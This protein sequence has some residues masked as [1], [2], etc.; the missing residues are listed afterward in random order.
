MN[1]FLSTTISL[2]LLAT[3][4]V[5]KEVAYRGS[6]EA[7]RTG[8]PVDQARGTVFLDANRNSRHDPGE[9][10][11]AGVMVSNGREVVT[12]RADGGYELPAYDD[13]NLFITKPAGYVTP[14]NDEMVPQF[15]YIHK[16]AGSPDLR[17]GGIA[18]TGPLPQAV[19]FPLIKDSVRDRFSC[20]VFGDTQAYT[21]AELG[22][23]RETAGKL[24]AERDNTATECLI[25]TGDVMGDDLSLYPRFKRIT[26]LGGVPQYFVG[27]NHD[28]DLDAETDQHSFDTFR[29]EWGPEYYSFDIGQVHFVGLDNV[30]YPCNGVDPHPF[31]AT[32]RS[33]TYNGVISQRQLEWLEND[34]A[35]VPKNKLI[36]LF[37][38][39]PFASFSDSTLSKH[40]TDNLHA[41]YRIVQGRPTLGLAG[42]THTT[43]QILP[44]ESYFGWQKNTGTGSAQF[45]QII[46]GAVSGSWWSGDLDDQGVPR[47]TQRLGSPRGYYRIDFN[48][49]SYTDTFIRFH[50]KEDAQFHAGFNT[51]RFRSWARK[52]LDYTTA[53]SGS[54]DQIPAVT[55]HDL[56]DPHLLTLEDLEAGTW[57]AVNVWNGSRDSTV[58][59]LV[60]GEKIVAHRTQA[61][62]G[63]ARHSGVDYADPVALALQSTVGRVA[64]RSTQGGEQT[65]GFSTW[66]GVAWK[67]LRPGPLKRNFLT[68][69][70]SHLWRADLPSTLT[71]GAHTLTVSTTDRYG[72]TYRDLIS[73]EVVETLPNPGWQKQGWNP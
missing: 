3:G 18:P 69:H 37:T 25:F 52:L 48:G 30:R 68:D 36:V 45:H 39:I 1:R 6:V 10:G 62:N 17:F 24:L 38:H 73:F 64:Y 32:D 15:S 43:E 14:V 12:T 40:Q 46:T 71:P 51:P 35:H 49:S 59:A 22:Y 5:A 70:S 34:L 54:W 23:V 56:G 16:I 60:D 7:L 50:A 66:Q 61:G 72:R 8:A 65:A 9:T 28:L 42:H 13:M 20:L 33:P 67:G 26:A 11:I 44:G 41:L 55:I 2:L 57:V 31:C 21:H 19:N 63:E 53:T 47:A 58:H 29:R 4:A 27:G